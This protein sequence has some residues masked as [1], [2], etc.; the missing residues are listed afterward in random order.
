MRQNKSVKSKVDKARA[1]ILISGGLDSATISAIAKSQGYELY[2][3]SFLY[4]QRHN[5]EL[6]FAKKQ[7]EDQGFK[8]H[9]IAEIDLRLFGNSALTADIEVPKNELEENSS[10]IPVTYVP[11]RNTIFL[12]YALAYAEVVEAEKIY[13]GVNALDYSGYPDCRPE[14]IQAFQE[15]ANLATKAAIEGDNV[16]IET[17]LINLSKADIIKAGVELGVDYS[18]T[19]SCYDPDEQGSACGQCDSCLLRKKGFEQAGVKDPTNYYNN[20]YKS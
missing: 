11:A 17:P 5:V 14:Y 13:I 18:K 7:V 20:H 9:K 1:V 12:S 19:I 15:M 3:L 4:G 6:D 8:D 16:E 10:E 2:G